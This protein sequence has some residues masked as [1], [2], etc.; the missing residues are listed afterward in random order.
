MA[1]DQT[2]PIYETVSKYDRIRGN[3]HNIALFTKPTTIETVQ[4]MTGKSD[5]FIV[6]TARTPHGDYVFLKNVDE[7]GVTRLALPPKVTATIAR[8]SDSLSKQNRKRKAKA[9]MRARIDAGENP[10]A[11][12]LAFRKKKLLKSKQ[13]E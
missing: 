11:H 9:A 5:T 7:N 2:T 10:A 4:D 6:E 8:Q 1:N 13:A 3:L 12:L